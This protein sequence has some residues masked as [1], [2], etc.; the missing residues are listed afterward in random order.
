MG[1]TKSPARMWELATGTRQQQ[2]CVSSR[3]GSLGDRWTEGGGGC[4][5]KVPGNS[6]LRTETWQMGRWETDREVGSRQ[7]AGRTGSTRWE[8]SMGVGVGMRVWQRAEVGKA[9]PDI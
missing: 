6:D 8:C 4:T 2:S 7:G 3:D 9:K 1:S 5:G